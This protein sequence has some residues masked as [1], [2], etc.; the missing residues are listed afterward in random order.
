MFGRARI[1]PALVK[2]LLEHNARGARGLALVRDLRVDVVDLHRDL[3][4]SSSTLSTI[5]FV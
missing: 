4:G 1:V 2:P 3:V 5:A